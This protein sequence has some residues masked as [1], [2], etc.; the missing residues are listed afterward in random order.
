M[1]DITFG[2]IVGVLG[3]AALFGTLAAMRH[4]LPVNPADIFP[5]QNPDTGMLQHFGGAAVE[6]AQNVI[7]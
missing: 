3:L 4:G 7:A 1:R 6:A 2:V 5:G